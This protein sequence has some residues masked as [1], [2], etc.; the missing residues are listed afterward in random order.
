MENTK[1]AIYYI[2]GK[3]VSISVKKYLE[4]IESKD[5]KKIADFIYNR[6]H[7]RYIKPFIYEQED[8]RVQYKNGFSIMA[9]CCLLIETLQ[10]FINGWEN[11]VGK[12]EQAFIQFLK[13]DPNFL[14]LKEK[15]K[16]FYKNV[17]CGILH[18]GEITNSWRISRNNSVL[19]NFKTK[20]IDA[21]V[22]LNL[23]NNSFKTYQKSLVD[24]DWDSAIW[25]NFRR[26]MRKTLKDC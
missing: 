18:Q 1:L 2:D 13:T 21:L 12:S 7:S 20:T 26:K 10:S 17:R 22:F 3:K 6:L 14:D 4:L 5:K 9:N 23:L 24:S 16:E 15:G 25:D 11:T 8:F 19:F